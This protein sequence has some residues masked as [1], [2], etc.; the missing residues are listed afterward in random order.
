[1]LVY[2]RVNCILMVIQCQCFLVASRIFSHKCPQSAIAIQKPI[3]FW[4]SK[5]DT[6]FNSFCYWLRL[7]ATKWLE[8]MLQFQHHRPCC[9][10]LN[11]EI[12]DD[13]RVSKSLRVSGPPASSC[14]HRM[15]LRWHSSS[16][17]AASC[18]RTEI[19][20]AGLNGRF[21]RGFPWDFAGVWIAVLALNGMQ[22]GFQWDL[23]Y[24][25]VLMTD[26]AKSV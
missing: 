9:S 8:M 25:W 16:V 26:L 22:L 5:S 18:W 15:I 23:V 20:R 11:G 3:Y 12:P 6:A 13:R 10:R 21:R 7:C 1:M 17:A 24:R 4:W 14:F 19:N 2:Q